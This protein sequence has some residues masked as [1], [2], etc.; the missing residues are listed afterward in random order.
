[1]ELSLIE[2]EICYL[3]GLLEGDSLYQPVEPLYIQPA[4]FPPILEQAERHME[5]EPKLKVYL[6]ALYADRW[7]EEL[8]RKAAFKKDFDTWQ[9]GINKLER[10]NNERHLF[11]DLPKHNHTV[12][13]LPQGQAV[14]P[15]SYA[16][17][18]S[19]SRSSLAIS[20][21]D[22]VRSEEELNQVLRSLLE[23]ERDNP[24]TRWM[25]TLAA[26]PSMIEAEPKALQHADFLCENSAVIDENYTAL[27]MPTSE[28]L[29]PDGRAWSAIWTED[30][31]RVF[32]EK[33]LQYPKS[34]AR[35]ASFLGPDKR[36][37]DCVQF[38]YRNKKRLKLKQRLMTYRRN[39]SAELSMPVK[40]KVGRPPR[41]SSL[42]L[43]STAIHPIDE[44]DEIPILSETE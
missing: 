26:I 9:A 22:I 27:T 12:S 11:E 42:V 16:G 31:E 35:I 10:D 32:V 20:G 7:K 34:F 18:R 8:G 21:G 1:M 33:Y 25:S 19:R 43:A 17:S 2:R 40:K 41:S 29:T 13:L 38:Y 37:G 23:Q 15:V 44:E 14:P 24:L 3:E 39:P 30:E 28:H 5:F 4:D 6:S 36:R